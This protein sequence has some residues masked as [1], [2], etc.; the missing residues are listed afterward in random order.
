LT[1]RGAAMFNIMIVDDE[2]AIRK[3]L[4]SFIDWESYGC[5]ISA[6]AIDGVDAVEKL[7][8]AE[9][10]I[11]ITDIKMPEMDGIELSK[12][13]YNKYPHI[14]TIILTAYDDFDYS[15]SAIKYGVVDFVLKL[16]STSKIIEAIEKAKA[17]IIKEKENAARIK[18]LESELSYQMKEVQEHLI[19]HLI[20]HI[21]TDQEKILKRMDL[22][23]IKLTHYCAVVLMVD[24]D[25][26]SSQPHSSILS[27]NNLVA[28]MLADYRHYIATV[29]MNQL[30]VFIDLT[31]PTGYTDS[32]PKIFSIFS[33]MIYI[34]DNLEKTGVNIGISSNHD[35]IDEAADAYNEAM[36][37]LSDRFYNI[38]K[39][40]IH[41]GRI[42]DSLD[43]SAIKLQEHFDAI[44]EHAK[45]GMFTETAYMLADMFKTF[46]SIHVPIETI[47]SISLQLLV[48]I[49]RLTPKDRH[50]DIS[51]SSSC[52]DR[53]LGIWHSKTTADIHEIL[54]KSI[55]SAIV[56][57]SNIP[58]SNNTIVKEIE[59]YILNHYKDDINLT[60]IADHVHMNGSYLSRLFKKETGININEKISYTRIEKAK[61]LLGS[62][63]M[64]I[65]EIAEQVGIKN[66]TYFSILFKKC[67][68]S[69]PNNYKSCKAN[70][71]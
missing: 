69:Y 4:T 8:K 31:S 24:D 40:H 67:T 49:D 62:T 25:N 22:L 63:D 46:K 14:K 32:T 68:G 45:S 33:E 34:M 13:I 48:A 57:A 29:S 5:K 11:V 6:V 17:L 28:S 56:A 44:I 1:R 52:N 55:T 43:N 7:E 26:A 64:K 36:L 18:A 35:R 60:T 39:I 66:P 51:I 23:N 61:E 70:K 30:C 27:L 19:L 3:G 53:Y 54:E 38:A 12:Y 41:S 65:Y 37:A 16:T 58:L 71:S 47:K 15:Q 21:E 10:D 50:L 59:K 20:K 9:P 2:P 42:D